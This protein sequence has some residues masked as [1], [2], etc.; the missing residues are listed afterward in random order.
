MEEQFFLINQKRAFFSSEDKVLLAVSGGMDSMVLLHLMQKLT[1]EIDATIAIA[2][3]NHQLREQSAMEEQ[4][5]KAY[6]QTQQLPFYC[7]HWTQT[8]DN[9]M[10]AAARTFRYAFFADVMQSHGYTKLVTAHHGDDQAETFLMKWLRG[11]SLKSHAGILDR[12]PWAQGELVRPLLY[13]SKAALQDYSREERIQF[14]E[15][16]TNQKEITLRNRLRLQVIPKIKAE[17]PQ[18]LTHVQQFS[19]QIQ[20]ADEVLTDMMLEKQQMV[21]EST[22]NGWKFPYGVLTDRRPAY[23]Y[24]FLQVFLYQKLAPL[25]IE[26]KEKQLQQILSLL[27]ASQPQWSVKLEKNWRVSREYEFILVEQEQTSSNDP[28]QLTYG[29]SLYLNDQEWLGLLPA[30]DLSAVPEATQ[31]WQQQSWAVTDQLP[32]PLVIRHRQEGDRIQL[33]K[34]LTKQLRRFFIDKKIGNSQ[35]QKAWVVCDVQNTLYALLPFTLSYLSIPQETD[36]IHYILLYK[37]KE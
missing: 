18:F 23:V 15:D 6:C 20:W 25:Q 17:N 26:V 7:T 37:F 1:K 31:Q 3:V 30:D 22:I 2:H 34:T 5:L 29:M 14:F 4:Y 9:G 32:E 13:F 12:Q 10:E 35:R 11:G 27:S 24:Y 16:E 28:M 19:K 36:K 21:V 8:S 33:T